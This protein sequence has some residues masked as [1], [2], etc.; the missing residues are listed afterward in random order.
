MMG[1][2]GLGRRL[3][4]QLLHRSAGTC[5]VPS[6]R[7]LLVFHDLVSRVQPV[8]TLLQ[9]HTSG[10]TPVSSSHRGTAQVTC[11]SWQ[12][13]GPTPFTLPDSWSLWQGPS[14]GQLSC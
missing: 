8:L 5:S 6:P 13:L 7:P 9:V 11:D 14:W 4:A 3:R 2:H 10:P 1:S 12:G